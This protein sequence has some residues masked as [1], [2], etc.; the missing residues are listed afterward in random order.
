VPLASVNYQ[1][2]NGE[3]AVLWKRTAARALFARI[4]A[5]KTIK[6]HRRAHHRSAAPPGNPSVLQPK[7]KTAAQAACH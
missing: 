3:S 1:A 6:H 4:K 5:D 2:P 7:P